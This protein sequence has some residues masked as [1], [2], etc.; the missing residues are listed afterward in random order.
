MRLKFKIMLLL[1]PICLA[2]PLMVGYWSVSAAKSRLISS[3]FKLIE[4]RLHEFVQGQVLRRY[5]VLKENKLLANHLYKKEYQEEIKNF[6][7]KSTDRSDGCIVIH[8]T[9]SNQ[10]YFNPKLV[11]NV[12]NNFIS[13]LLNLG[14]KTKGSLQTKDANYLFAKTSFKPWS[15]ELYWIYP[16]DEIS[17]T[18]LQIKQATW[19]VCL[20]IIITLF[21]IINV[22]VHIQLIKPIH[23]LETAA[24][25]I[26]DGDYHFHSEI[27]SKNEL[28]NLSRAMQKMGQNISK[29][30][31]MSQE[32]QKNLMQEKTKAESA[33]RAKSNFLATMSHE[34]RT[35]LNGILGSAQILRESKLDEK[36]L[37]LTG[38]ISLS[39]Q[40]LLN[41]ING[42]LDYSKL[43]SEEITLD[44]NTFNLYSFLKE[45]IALFQEQVRKQN[46]T[47][48]FNISQNTPT[49]I[50]GDTRL[51]RQVLMNLIGNSNK[52]TQNGWIKINVNFE[53]TPE[54]QQNPYIHFLVQDTGIGFDKKT[55]ENMFK[56]FNHGTNINAT[57]YGGSGLGLTICLKICKLMNGVIKAESEL[58]KGST[59]KFSIP[60]TK[61]LHENSSHTN[62]ENSSHTNTND[63]PISFEQC[64]LHVL[65]VEDNAINRDIMEA[66]LTKLG[67]E[68][69][70][71]E[72]GQIAVEKCQLKNYNLIFMDLRMPIMD[73]QSSTRNIRSLQNPSSKAYIVALTANT[74]DEDI[75]SSFESGMN[76]FI[77]KPIHKQSLI[78]VFREYLKSS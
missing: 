55:A 72:N 33:S 41:L 1:L 19:V 77:P 43:E 38:T 53:K 74:T 46:N 44:L 71:A 50:T 67:I 42:I 24:K 21:I 10:F 20:F 62:T 68:A 70:F 7:L 58:G 76:K 27:K 25:N 39:G 8:N 3:S 9:T 57:K 52:F 61:F 22:L 12:D 73:G 64:N 40:N 4:F 11:E 17:K 13:S 47:L 54:H 75:K 30:F 6:V 5:Q 48:E 15:W 37:E 31:E 78:K 59:F 65:V 28:G 29:Q 56:D 34:L 63:T 60:Q 26:S 23:T 35:P 2:G 51:I 45:I 18:V 14:Q 66:F 16:E 36:Q 49:M 69:D 32:L